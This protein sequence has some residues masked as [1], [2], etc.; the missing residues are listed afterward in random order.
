M[1]SLLLSPIRSF[2]QKAAAFSNKAL[3]LSPTRSASAE[4]L[5]EMARFRIL[6]HHNNFGFCDVSAAYGRSKLKGP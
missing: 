2:H 1:K 5:R 4:F 6:L 3:L